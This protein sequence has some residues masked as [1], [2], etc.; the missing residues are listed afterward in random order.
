M[1]PNLGRLG[2]GRP[3]GCPGL[4]SGLEGGADP[5]LAGIIGSGDGRS[6]PR[7]YWIFTDYTHVAYRKVDKIALMFGIVVKTETTGRIADG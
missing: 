7:S 5:G 3:G 2:L 4:K 6:P 1:S